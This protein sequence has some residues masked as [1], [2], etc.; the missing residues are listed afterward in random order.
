MFARTV[1]M[2]LKPNART[3]FTQLLESIII[4]TLRKQKGFQDE[5]T[6]VG[7]DGTKVTAISLWDSKEDAESYNRVSYPGVLKSL[8]KIIEGI[9]VVRTADVANSTFH[10]IAAP[11]AA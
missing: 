9:P 6:L 4:P 10:K 5:I 11:A 8:V 7:S 3:E 2:H 1:S